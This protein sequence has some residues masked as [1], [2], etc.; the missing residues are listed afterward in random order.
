MRVV[1]LD[2]DGVLQPHN[3]F[4]RFKYM[5]NDTISYLSNKYNCDYFKYDSYDVC[6]VYVDWSN[7]AVERLKYILDYTGSKII[8]SSNW[9]DSKNIYKMRDLFK[10]K[11]LDKYWKDDNPYII[12]Q[13]NYYRERACEINA[14]IN[15][16]DISNYVILDDM[17]ELIRYFPDNFVCT[18]GIL[19]DEDVDRSIKILKK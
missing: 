10:I 9:R 16:Y 17:V 4:E 7:D 13:E 14:S 18:R 6:S 11:G 12:N 2:I 19:Q 3:S 1:F 15:K 8:V 5:N